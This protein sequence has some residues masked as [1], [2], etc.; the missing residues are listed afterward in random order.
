MDEKILQRLCFFALEAMLQGIDEMLA[1]WKSGAGWFALGGAA[2]GIIAMGICFTPWLF[3]LLPA[4]LI[5]AVAGKGIAEELNRRRSMKRWAQMGCPSVDEMVSNIPFSSHIWSYDRHPQL[6][7][8]QKMKL[9]CR[10]KK[11]KKKR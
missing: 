4:L 10:K 9:L 8:V 5:C 3:L 1:E 2:T 11:A 6:N 7:T